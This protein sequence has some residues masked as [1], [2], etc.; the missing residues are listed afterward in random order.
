MA[1]RVSYELLRSSDSRNW[2]IVLFV[3]DQGCLG[4][5]NRATWPKRHNDRPKIPLGSSRLQPF[6]YLLFFEM[7]MYI[8]D[9]NFA[10]RKGVFYFTLL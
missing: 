10:L 5:T 6:L 9:K 1:T 8:L 7:F 3:K 2:G 4:L